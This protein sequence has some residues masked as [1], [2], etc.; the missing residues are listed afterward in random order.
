M[1]EQ[2]TVLYKLNV[3]KYLKNY[4]GVPKNETVGFTDDFRTD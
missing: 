4:M 2:L 3:K 1:V